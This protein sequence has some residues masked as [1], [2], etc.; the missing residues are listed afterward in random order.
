[1]R[2]GRRGTVG[3]FA[4]ASLLLGFFTFHELSNAQD[5]TADVSTGEAIYEQHCVKCHG[6]PWTDLPRPPRQGYI[7]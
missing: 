2:I 6:Q 4:V 3:L 5:Q 1:M 7:C